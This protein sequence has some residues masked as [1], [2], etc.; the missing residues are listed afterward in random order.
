MGE[1]YRT[2]PQLRWSDQDLN[3]H[4]N[5]AKIVTLLEEARI[6]WLIGG[7]ASG[8]LAQ[9]KL[10]A[11]LELDYRRP[12]QYGSEL[13]IELTISHI[14]TTSFSVRG[15]G[16]QEGEV[17]FEAVDVLVVLDKATGRP[18]PLSAAG[19]AY[20]E[21]YLDDGTAADGR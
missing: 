3:H 17:C 5:N 16:L 19:R 4:V 10:V 8:A 9:P 15:V 1:V 13:T 6:G 2:T 21:R 12:V 20:L 11:R 7:K 14:G 18:T